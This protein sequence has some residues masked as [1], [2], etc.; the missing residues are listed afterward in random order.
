VRSNTRFIHSLLAGRVLRLKVAA[1]DP[2]QDLLAAAVAVDRIPREMVVG[3]VGPQHVVLPR[4][5]DV[6]E[7]RPLLAAHPPQPRRE[8]LHVVDGHGRRLRPDIDRL[9]DLPR[10]DGPAHHEDLAVRYLPDL[11]DHA[12]HR[13]D[14]EAMA[15]AGDHHEVGLVVEHEGLHAALVL[16]ILAAGAAADA[17]HDL[18]LGLGIGAGQQ[19]L[20]ERVRGVV[21]DAVAEHHDPQRSA[22]GQPL[23]RLG[24][25]LP[26][27]GR[28]L[29]LHH[30]ALRREPRPPCGR[31]VGG[32]LLD[33]QVLHGQGPRIGLEPDPRLAG[34]GMAAE[35]EHIRPPV[36]GRVDAVVV[37]A[38]D[39]LAVLVEE[40]RRAERLL[41]RLG[42]EPE[43]VEG[44]RLDGKGLAHELA[45]P[46]T[47]AVLVGVVRQPDRVA[48]ERCRGLRGLPAIGRRREAEIRG[49]ERCK[50][51]EPDVAVADRA[52]HG[53][54][55]LQR[56]HALLRDR[57]VGL[58]VVDCL[59]AVDREL[60]PPT[61]AA[62]HVFVPAVLRPSAGLR[63]GLLGRCHEHSVA[64][65]LV[66]ETA[67]VGVADVGLVADHLVVVGNA[68]GAELNAGIEVL[69]AV[70]LVFE[71]ELEV[72]ERAVGGEELILRC[73]LRRA[74]RH[75]RAILDP[76]GGFRVAVPAREGRA[77]EE[78]LHRRRRRLL[79]RGHPRAGDG[80]EGGHQGQGQ[81]Q[82][83][84]A[85]R[86]G[87][88]ET[89]P[90]G[91]S[92]GGRARTE[93]SYIHTIHMALDVVLSSSVSFWG[94]GR[95][96][97]HGRLEG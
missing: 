11:P 7:F 84:A 57:G 95:G 45:L 28:G 22:A 94:F 89:H 73:G 66:V 5:A 15:D 1:E 14:V 46:D 37:V 34:V 93:E 77:V 47:D 69:T 24:E 56:D 65:A 32:D 19:C 97:D 78:R 10:R 26:A 67:L 29:E 53:A 16:I 72:A 87:K 64:A 51:I 3:L 63:D 54:V 4:L 20:V 30:R 75:D 44:E 25:K 80:E 36:S 18:D 39:L 9:V 85:G 23:H 50:F 59:D 52:H 13:L 55:D 82:R 71:A 83:L 8:L 79:G 70:D 2:R 91:L 21:A 48:F 38:Y 81:A 86:R 96:G 27:V 92:K 40:H 58:R 12:A 61:L 35:A 68:D 49:E 62:D 42:E 41:R 88:G 76:P 33:P 90:G 17:R 60:D 74:A 31:L 43:P 6:E